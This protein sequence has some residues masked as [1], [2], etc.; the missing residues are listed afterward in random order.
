VQEVVPAGTSLDRARELAAVI[1]ANAPMAVAMTKELVARSRDLSLA[2]GLRLYHA[3]NTMIHAS[4]DVA[5]GT[6][7]F[8]DR[9][10]PQFRGR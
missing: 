7:A 6:Q 5:E 8:A 2:D 10:Q 4:D 3:Y 1:C 9:R